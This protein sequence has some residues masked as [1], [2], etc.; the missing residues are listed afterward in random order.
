MRFDIQ[1]CS[2]FIII[3]SQKNKTRPV[4]V[5]EHDFMSLFLCHL[6]KEHCVSCSFFS[7]GRVCSI[8]CILSEDMKDNNCCYEPS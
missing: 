2:L 3:N 4:K 7:A 5:Q 1:I 6:I 8:V